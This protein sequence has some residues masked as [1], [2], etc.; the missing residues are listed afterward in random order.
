MAFLFGLIATISTLA[1]IGLAILPTELSVASEVGFY[2]I[3]TI[4]V[5]MFFRG[6]MSR[7]L[8]VSICAWVVIR[9][10]AWRF[11]TLPLDNG[12][13]SSTG[14]ILLLMAEIYGTAMML[15]GL[16]VNANPMERKPAT[17]PEREED[18]PTVDIYIPT[19]SEGLNIVAPTVMGAMSIDYPSDKFK[20][21]VLDD[22]YPR[23]LTS[24]NP[25][26]AQEL[27]DRAEALK[28]LCLKHGAHYLTRDNNLH[29]KSGNMNSAMAHTDGE[30]ILV[31]DAD[32]VP[33]QN[34][35]KNMVGFFKNPKMAFV[36]SPHFFLNADPVEKNLNLFHK[37]PAEND[38]FYRVVQKG[39]DLW[40]TSFFCGSAALIR[41]TAVENVGG[42]STESIT[43]DASTSIKMHQ[44]GWKSAYL[45]VPMVAGLQPE[46]FS[47]FIV[48]RLRWGMGMAQIMMKQNPWL[49]PGLSLGQRIS[50]SSVVLFWLFP[51]ARIIFFLSPLLSV[52]G[53]L[54][55]YPAGMEY[56]YAYT[57]PY[58]IAVVLST[59]KIF[60]RVR[61]IMTSEMYETLQSFYIFPAL[62]STIVKPNAPTFKVTPKGERLDTE[63]VSEFKLPF[64]FFFAL[65]V[66]GLGYGI[67][68]L[69]MEPEVRES[70][71]LS[72]GWLGFNFILLCAAMGTLFEQVQRRDRPRVEVNLPVKV[73]NEA[74]EVLNTRATLKDI[75][76]VGALVTVGK[77]RISEQDRIILDLPELSKPINCEVMS[78]KSKG[79][80]LDLGV[81][82]KPD[83][84]EQ[85][86]ELVVLTYG[87][88][89]RWEKIWIDREAPINVLK[90]LTMFTITAIR[91]LIAHLKHVAK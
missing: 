80:H 32:H 72:V 17:L 62:L 28:A 71:S 59:E 85:E 38:M 56:F 30:L 70:L 12:W 67:F 14:A 23:S 65:T 73:L 8:F 82:F 7:V 41:R 10:L 3:I 54:M 22:G 42:F 24:T 66:S 79:T 75:T 60:G 40:N 18:F 43:E 15:F 63:F 2:S 52:F 27:A 49:I 13:A 53:G 4:I 61:Q 26:Q 16:F 47:S 48:Q 77:H 45:G 39:L 5:L 91:T 81:K 74:N 83:T 34:I 21:Y 55:I 6:K 20:V 46:T 88:S 69:I 76:E 68:R 25:E 11:T 44:K 84:P 19:Y 87:N 86:R 36:Q 33:T 78:V 29:A 1:L 64:Y 35:L 9:Y 89:E 37:M 51:F 58:L 50:Y 31:L 57:V 90:S